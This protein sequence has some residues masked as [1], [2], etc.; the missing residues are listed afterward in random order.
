[1]SVTLPVPVY[2]PAL[3]SEE[4]EEAP[5][6][7]IFSLRVALRLCVGSSASSG[8][9]SVHLEDS[10]GTQAAGLEMQFVRV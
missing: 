3:A 10:V 2:S 6:V 4:S 7:I 5:A 8:P 1:M 9:R